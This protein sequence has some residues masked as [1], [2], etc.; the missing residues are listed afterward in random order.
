METKC[1]SASISIAN[2]S[3]SV[4]FPCPKCGKT[5]IVRSTLARKNAMKYKCS[6]CGFEGPN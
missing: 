2:D 1:N 5:T 3:G 6:E 4:Q